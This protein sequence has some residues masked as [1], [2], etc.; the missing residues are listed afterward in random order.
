VKSCEPGVLEDIVGGK[1]QSLSCFEVIL[2]DTVLFPE[3]G[4]QVLCFFSF[5]SFFLVLIFYDSEPFMLFAL[6]Y[7]VLNNRV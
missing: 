5:F 1:K 2:D 4:G 3:G 7:F 6:G